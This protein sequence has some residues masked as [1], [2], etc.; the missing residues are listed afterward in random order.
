MT[1]NFF[2]TNPNKLAD[3]PVFSSNAFERIVNNMVRVEGPAVN[4]F[5]VITSDTPLFLYTI[6]QHIKDLLDEFLSHDISKMENYDDE[7]V[8][9]GMYFVYLRLKAYLGSIYQIPAKGVLIPP[10]V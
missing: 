10:G 6:T 3:F 2:Q 4:N 1:D 5:V 7:Y 9:R 8:K